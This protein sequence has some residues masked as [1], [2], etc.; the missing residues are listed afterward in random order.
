[1][2]ETMLFDRELD[3]SVFGGSLYAQSSKSHKNVSEDRTPYAA[4]LNTSVASVTDLWRLEALFMEFQQMVA[5]VQEYETEIPDV[6]DLRPLSSQRITLK[7][8][9]I[10]PAQFYFIPDMD[11][12]EE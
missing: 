12:N 2:G 10:K 3:T 9:D 5:R 11:D 7:I 1:M 8:K 6:F 4:T